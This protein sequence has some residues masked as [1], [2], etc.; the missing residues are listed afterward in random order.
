MPPVTVLLARFFSTMTTPKLARSLAIACAVAC[1][2]SGLSSAAPSVKGHYVQSSGSWNDD[3]TD[4]EQSPGFQSQ[5]AELQSSYESTGYGDRNLGQYGAGGGVREPQDAYNREDYASNGD[6]DHSDEDS[7]W[8][9][10][11]NALTN[12]GAN[13]AQNVARG[14]REFGN[15]V[16][17]TA[18]GL[19]NKVDDTFDDVWNHF[20]DGLKKLGNSIQQGAVYCA[21]VLQ[22]KA[23]DVRSSEFLQKLEDKVDEGNDQVMEFFQ[24][25]GEKIQRWSEEHADD[26]SMEDRYNGDSQLYQQGRIEA[27]EREGFPD[28][29]QDTEV[30]GEIEKLVDYGIIEQD[31]ADLFVQQRRQ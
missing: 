22:Q 2:L 12:W 10:S 28:L 17:D 15:D 5:A 19:W 18:T 27:F 30:Q 31:E 13:V 21:H 23:D 20:M 24:V 3:L 8:G 16:S 26:D 6:Y 1:F 9:E 7:T 4:Q 29:F 11:W 14:A 25:L